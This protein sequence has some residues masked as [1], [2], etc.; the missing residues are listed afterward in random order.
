RLCRLQSRKRRKMSP[1]APM[2]AS[3]LDA[4]A[5]VVLEQFASPYRPHSLEAL[6]NRGGFSG[7]RL[8]RCQ[9]SRGPSCLRAWPAD[10]PP[11]PALAGL[12]TLMATAG[13]AGLA[14]VPEVFP[15]R[16]GATW[17]DQAGRLWELTSWL[18]GRADFHDNPTPARLGAACN[19]LARLH[20]AWE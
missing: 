16:W 13:H 19:A 4:A 10:G 8:W 18:P 15:T 5:H 7:A 11:P 9:G 1:G 20:T 14:F 2:S 17:V 3:S 12:H 6:G